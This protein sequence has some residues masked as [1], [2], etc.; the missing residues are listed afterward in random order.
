[1]FGALRFR[2]FFKGTFLA[3]FFGAA[4]FGSS[5]TTGASTSGAG[6][7]TF[8]A[9]SGAYMLW[10]ESEDDLIVRRGQIKVV[11]RRRN[12]LLMTD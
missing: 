8:G 3:A 12:C 11:I 10:D 4:A 1:M 6:A 5:S 7:S 2:F 9:T